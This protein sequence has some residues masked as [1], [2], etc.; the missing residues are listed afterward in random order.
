MEMTKVGYTDIS[1]VRQGGAL[2]HLSAM[3]THFQFFMS[4]LSGA[5]R[6][7]D[8]E[9]IDRDEAKDYTLEVP[10][11]ML[12]PTAP[13]K[14][15]WDILIM[16]LILYSAVSIPVHLCFDVHAEGWMWYFEMAMSIIFLTDVALAFNTA[17]QEDGYWVYDRCLI[18]RKYLCG[19][20]WI[21]FPSAV[22][23]ELVELII[24]A[25]DEKIEDLATLRVLRIL[26]L[27]RLLRLL[28]V[29]EYITRIEEAFMINLRVLKLVE[30][31]VKLGFI[32]HILGCGF[33]YMHLLADED[34][35]TWVSEYD[36]GSA[37]DGTLTKQYLYAIYWSLT[38]MST[39]GY[40][41]I[42]PVNDRERWFA[43]MALVVGALSFAF[44]NG[45]VVSLLSTLDNQTRLV[46]GKMES[47]KEYVQ[48]RSLPKELVIRIR[49]YYEHY[50]TRRAVFDEAD[51]LTQLNPQLHAEVVNHILHEQLGKLSLFT[52]LN[53]D[54]TLELFPLLKPISFAP[55]D[56]IFKKGQQS[57]S[58][59]F[60]LSGEIDVFR[61]LS[62]F[63]PTS[64]ITS[65]HE[66]DLGN[67]TDWA[68][69]QATS[70]I[71]A[72]GHVLLKGGESHIAP[73]QTHEGIFGQ[74]ALL[75]RRRE[76]TAVAR[77]G[78]EALLIAK[79]DLHRLF[80]GDAISARRMCML[81]LDDF[82][83]MDRLSMLAL[84]LRI[85]WGTMEPEVRAALNIQY[86]WRRY[87]D[88][89]AQA[90]D[91][92]YELIDKEGQPSAVN[93]KQLW[94]SRSNHSRLSLGSS[95]SS[96]NLL[97]GSKQNLSNRAHQSFR[98][99]RRLRNNDNSE[100]VMDRLGE[101]MAVLIDMRGRIENLEGGSPGSATGLGPNSDP[102]R[103]FKQG[104]A[105]SK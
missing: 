84:R 48:W 35:P 94:A 95:K 29:K 92:I 2:D 17:Y 91:P 64:R 54:F 12:M 28:K 15:S 50:Y 10:A 1:Q 98:G 104:S 74:A 90:N 20:F 34:E 45:N 66:I 62:P 9:T 53:P 7:E 87:N 51:I 16:T 80:E 96:K 60:L 40:G 49:R 42:T 52:K 69:N 8:R 21:D 86:H 30:I 79:D 14:E 75:G 24:G 61:G 102:R 85:L 63:G 31:F 89:L 72:T 100:A 3:G 59:Y 36:G 33:F 37:I 76:C 6:K 41:D 81:V 97:G 56:T 57:R 68:G 93:S 103:L 71:S 70:R 65:T 77:T 38:T 67:V 82:L 5:Q 55:G 4:A 73:V 78:C 32:A 46:E 18:A 26:R 83:R 19:W 25:R 13:L 44:I 27:F 58:I 88:L 22:P 43:T 23:V 101:V 99:G 105:A 47:V 11:G 39:V